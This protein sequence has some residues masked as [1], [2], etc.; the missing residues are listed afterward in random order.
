MKSIKDI[1]VENITYVEYARSGV[2]YYTIN[3]EEVKELL[4]SGWSFNKYSKG[5][6]VIPP[7]ESIVDITDY[8]KVT[9]YENVIFNLA[10]YDFLTELIEN[11]L[12][13][14]FINCI[15]ESK[16]FF[17]K[18]FEYLVSYGPIL[19]TEIRIAGSDNR[20]K[21]LKMD[22]AES[23]I[24][25]K[26]Y[27]TY[28]SKVKEEMGV[29]K[30]LKTYNKSFEELSQA[31]KDFYNEIEENIS[32]FKNIKPFNPMIYKYY[33]INIIEKLD[34]D[35]ILFI[36]FGCFKYMSSF[37]NKENFSK[38][39]LWEV[40]AEESKESTFKMFNKNMDGKKVLII[41]SMYSGKTLKF[42]KNKV[43]ERGGTPILLSMGPKNKNNILNSDY[44]LILNTIFKTDKL[45]IEETNFFRNKYLSILGGNKK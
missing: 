29:P 6:R 4:K 14:G 7:E 16:K 26:E 43:L 8:K 41:D 34:A 39:M 37:V 28:Y 21:R 13:N 30:E 20:I 3:I 32:I 5:F 11:N 45:K 38:V 12:L 10:Y 9:Q 2:V 22:M 1:F 17:Y 23:F 24:K 27:S 42:L 15:I 33:N 18:N 35:I 36:P 25:S 31:E 44:T 40:H 19:H